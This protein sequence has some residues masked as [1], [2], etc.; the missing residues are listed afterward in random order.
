[1]LWKT[2]SATIRA[3]AL[4]TIV[5]LLCLLFDRDSKPVQWWLVVPLVFSVLI[6]LLRVAR[7]IWVLEH[8]I[9][10]LTKPVPKA[11]EP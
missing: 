11:R 8:I 2:F 9:A 1:V 10:L 4:G 7:T 5:A 3:L 6:S